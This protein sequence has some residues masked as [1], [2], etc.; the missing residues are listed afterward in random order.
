MSTNWEGQLLEFNLV[1]ASLHDHLQGTFSVFKPN[2]ARL[3]VAV[4]QKRGVWVS[5]EQCTE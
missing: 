3:T 5:R 1:T 2:F 4:S